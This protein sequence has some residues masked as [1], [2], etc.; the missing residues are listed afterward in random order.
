MAKTAPLPG[1]DAA[2]VGLVHQR[3]GEALETAGEED[4]LDDVYVG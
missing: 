3:R 2:H 4:G 1:G